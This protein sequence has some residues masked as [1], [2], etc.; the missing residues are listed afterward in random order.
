MS[1]P[2][3]LPVGPTRL[4]ESKTSMPPPDPKSRTV[5]PGFNSASAVGFP[6]PSDA[7][8]AASGKL[9]VWPASYRLL[10]MGSQ[11][12]S[13][14]AAAPQHELP[15]V[16]TRSAAWPYFSRTISLMS[17]MVFSYLQMVMM[18]L[19]L[20]ALLRVQHSA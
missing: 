16:V 12:P 6:Q 8:T 2:Y 4:A 15:P 10:V 13:K 5:S 17:G 18:V 3:A 19:G 11:Q 1:N 14:A 7:S 20:M 9:P